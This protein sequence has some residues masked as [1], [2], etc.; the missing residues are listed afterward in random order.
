MCST[1]PQQWDE[2]SFPE[3]IFT[4]IQHMAM[5]AAT[6]RCVNLRFFD[7]CSPIRTLEY[8]I[9]QLSSEK[10]DLGGYDVETILR[11]LGSCLLYRFWLT[12]NLK[13]T[14]RTLDFVMLWMAG[15]RVLERM[16]IDTKVEVGLN[17]VYEWQKIWEDLAKMF[18]C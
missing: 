8:Y 15:D 18:E 6:D 10:F 12:E 16:K 1:M 9:R 2:C 3:A 7:Y 13:V 17:A 14:L 11:E 4:L 5:S